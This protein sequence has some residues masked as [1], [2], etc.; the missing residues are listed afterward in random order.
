V[1]RSASTG[2]EA[3]TRAARVEKDKKKKDKGRKG[4][5]VQDNAADKRDNVAHE[6]QQ[7]SQ[8]P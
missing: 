1:K 2:E 8:S 6:H 7:G 4:D 3:E 5:N